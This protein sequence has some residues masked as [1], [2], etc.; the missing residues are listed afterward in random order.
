M[1]GMHPVSRVDWL[2]YTWSAVV[3]P[4]RLF[5]DNQ[6]PTILLI[7][8]HLRLDE[9]RQER[10]SRLWSCSVDIALGHGNDGQSSQAKL[11]SALS[12]AAL[13]MHR[14]GPS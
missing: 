3:M 6:Q 11:A 2:L 9:H 4:C 13:L 8:L 12:H 1:S 5:V 14:L 10:C 7:L